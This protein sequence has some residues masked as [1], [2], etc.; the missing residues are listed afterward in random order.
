MQLI[1]YKKAESHLQTFPPAGRRSTAIARDRCKEA[2]EWHAASN[3]LAQS[4]L[5]WTLAWGTAAS[6]HVENL[7][8]RGIKDGGS[9]TWQ[10]E[11]SVSSCVEK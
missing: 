9:R 7:N 6:Y 5:V 8:T 11:S 4:I 2:D 10:I 1:S 3:S